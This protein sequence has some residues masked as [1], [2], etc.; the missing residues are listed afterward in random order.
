MHIARF[1]LFSTLLFSVSHIHPNILL[2]APKIISTEEVDKIAQEKTI[3]FHWRWGV[4]F[5]Y[6]QQKAGFKVVSAS[7]VIFEYNYIDSYYDVFPE[8]DEQMETQ[9]YYIAQP[10]CYQ[11]AIPKNINFE[12]LVSLLNNK[13]FI[14]YTGAG[15]SA[16]KVGTMYELEQSLCIEDG[17]EKFLKI[18]QQDPE[19]SVQSFANFCHSALYGLPTLA[20]YAVK[21]IE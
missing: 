14:F 12:Q 21:D 3:R 7:N 10:L 20:H 6:E 2:Q 15:I 19:K 4:Y 8:Q 9:Q 1:I 18:S 13:K 11:Q 17:I 5:S 16:G